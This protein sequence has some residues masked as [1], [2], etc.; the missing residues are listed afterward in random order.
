MLILPIFAKLKVDSH[1]RFPFG[2][3]EQILLISVGRKLHYFCATHPHR[4]FRGPGPMD[5]F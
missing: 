2:E 5:Q 3:D 4:G 1:P